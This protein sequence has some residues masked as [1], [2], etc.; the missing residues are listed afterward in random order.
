MATSL[1][2]SLHQEQ[3]QG[4]II[5]RDLFESNITLGV[6]GKSQFLQPLDR[7]AG[8]EVMTYKESEKYG[9]RT[10]IYQ[11]SYQLEGRSRTVYRSFREFLSFFNDLR[12]GNPEKVLPLFPCKKP[13]N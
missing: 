11:I 13:G 2:S 4:Q 9:K 5:R 3:E 12:V 6:E 8:I 7:V 1:R 10:I